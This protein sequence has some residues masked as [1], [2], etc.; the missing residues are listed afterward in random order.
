MWDASF[1]KKKFFK[2][3]SNYFLSRRM[4]TLSSVRLSHF[5]GKEVRGW[6]EVIESLA[7]GAYISLSFL[8]EIW[9]CPSLLMAFVVHVSLKATG[10]KPWT[11]RCINCNEKKSISCGRGRISSF[12]NIGSVWSLYLRPQTILIA[13]FCLM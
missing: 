8:K 12:L 6:L 7:G 9:L 11:N 3:V 5:L 13:I 2:A 10:K 1:C 4:R